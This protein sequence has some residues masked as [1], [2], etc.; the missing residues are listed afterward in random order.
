[1]GSVIRGVQ[2]TIAWVLRH[3][4]L[5]AFLLYSDHGGGLLAAAITF[6]ALFAVFAAVLLG[7]SIASMWL[8]SR[9]DLWDALV[10]SV[11]EVI[12]GLLSTDGSGLIDASSITG[13]YFQQNIIVLIVSVPALVWALIGAVGNLRVAVRQIAGT[14]HEGDNAL[15][16]R[17]FDLLFALSLGVLLAASAVASLLGTGFVDLVLGWIGTAPSGTA[18]VL[19]R[20]GTIVVTFVLDSVVIAWLFWLLSGLR[21]PPRIMLSGALLGG[22]GLVVLQQLSSLF[23]GGADNNP[24]LE[25]FIPLIALL[26]WFNFSSQVILIASAYIV[27]SVEDREN[28]VASRYGADT[29]KQRAV[30]AAERD[31]RVAT[32]ALR[33]AREAERVEREKIA[34]RAERYSA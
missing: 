24:L 26:L 22:A 15:L 16:L 31:L 20:V 30:R 1:M 19:T 21:T 2:A 8:S 25:G 28:R 29:F 13:D 11:D 33:V 17:A 32:D 27:V 3:R 12:P 5:R 14:A 6:R 23:V 7:F 4:I 10:A 34:E 9:D 18:T